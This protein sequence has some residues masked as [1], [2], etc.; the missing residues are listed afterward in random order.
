[1][2]LLTEDDVRR[3]LPMEAAIT[4]VEAALREQGQDRAQ[5]ITRGR[6]QTQNIM[7]HLLGGA[8]NAARAIGYKAYTTGRHGARFHVGLFDGESG[9]A[10]ALIQAD[11]LGQLR[12]GAAGGVAVKYM[13]RADADVAGI[14]GAGKQARTQ[15]WAIAKVRPL[16]R[17]RVFSRNE[18]NRRAFVKEMTPLCECEIE[19]VTRAEEAVRDTDIV[20]TATSSKTP[21][22]TG[23]WL[24][25][26]TH[27][28]AVGSNFM[29]KAELDSAVFRRAKTVVVDSKDQARLEA[30]DFAA[31]LEEGVLHWPDVHELHQVVVGRFRGRDHP[32]DVTVFKSLGLGLEDVAVAAHVYAAALTAGVGR[33]VEF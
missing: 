29:H 1:M 27:L 12:T 33:E 14:I 23:S 4:A 30:G 5:N 21:V 10:L 6:C 20:I 8:A 22:L 11:A 28:C 31:A 3:L 24:A 9:A 16:R 26:G 2:L 25:Q 13:A 19:P 32:E 17:L 7:L 15:A 18:E